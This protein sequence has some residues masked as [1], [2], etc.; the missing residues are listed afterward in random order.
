LFKFLSFFLIVT[1]L[2]SDTGITINLSGK[3]V[4]KEI[5]S[6]FEFSI[7]DSKQF[8]YFYNLK[9]TNEEEIKN[10]FYDNFFY[11]NVILQLTDKIAGK[12]FFNKERTKHILNDFMSYIEDIT[13][14]HR[15]RRNNKDYIFYQVKRNRLDDK[16][17]YYE[18]Y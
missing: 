18:L 8:L 13:M 3:E 17:K 7:S 10:D 4:E 15:Y 12:G 5:G 16:I 9:D 6:V 11:D 2:L 14:I 1:S